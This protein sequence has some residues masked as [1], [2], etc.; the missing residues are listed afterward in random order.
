IVGEELGF[1]GI[2]SVV[3]VFAFIVVRGLRVAFHAAD[4]YGGYLAVGITIFIG[5]QGF[6]NL[7]VAMGLV[8]T[9]GL[10]LPFISYGGSSLL[11]NCAAMG[12]LLNVSRPRE[13]AEEVAEAQSAEP[14]RAR[15]G[16]RR[17]SRLEVAGGGA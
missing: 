2:L 17:R 5:L 7:A 16:A 11:V 14:A 6:T 9:K 13:A 4:D 8:P 15:A 10:V 3:S 12:V 1:V